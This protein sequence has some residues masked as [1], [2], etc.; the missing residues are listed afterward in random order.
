[1]NFIRSIKNWIAPSFARTQF[2]KAYQQA[3]QLETASRYETTDGRSGTSS[4]TVFFGIP[5]VYT[6]K[7]K[8]ASMKDLCYH[9][10]ESQREGVVQFQKDPRDDSYQAVLF[11]NGG[12]TK[13]TCGEDGDINYD[14]KHYSYKQGATTYYDAAFE[15]AFEVL[16][17]ENPCS[18]KRPV[19]KRSIWSIY[20]SFS[21]F[22][23][24][25]KV[26]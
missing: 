3:S 11:T 1:M 24:S 23:V 10:C 19:F 9:G 20:I 12:N 5:V 25:S 21:P 13:V 2:G 15:K 6:Y 16:G 22:L 14:G 8:R 17:L 18:T 4:P 7:T 26:K